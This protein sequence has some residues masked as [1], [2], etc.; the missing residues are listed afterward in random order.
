MATTISAVRTVENNFDAALENASMDEILRKALAGNRAALAYVTGRPQLVI[1]FTATVATSSDVLV[2]DLTSTYGLL[3]PVARASRIMRADLYVGDASEAAFSRS[4]AAVKN[5]SGTI[6]VSG[7]ATRIEA[8]DGGSSASC[9]QLVVSTAN[10]QLHTEGTWADDVYEC[11]AEIYLPRPQGG[12]I[13]L[14]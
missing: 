11:V 14:V 4:T 5:V 12:V 10:L 13:S 9:L 8:V 6:S 2:V 1:S 7:A 3:A